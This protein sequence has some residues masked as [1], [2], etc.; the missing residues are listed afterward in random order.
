[1]LKEDLG[2][3]GT[4]V[5]P[6]DQWKEHGDEAFSPEL[7]QIGKAVAEQQ[8]GAECGPFSDIPSH[9]NWGGPQQNHEVVEEKEQSFVRPESDVVEDGE[10]SGRGTE[11]VVE[12]AVQSGRGTEEGVEDGEQSGRGTEEV[13]ED[14]EQSDRGTEEGVQDGEQ[15]LLPVVVETNDVG[16]D[17]EQSPV[18]AETTEVVDRKDDRALAEDAEETLKRV[19]ELSIDHTEDLKKCWTIEPI[20]KLWLGYC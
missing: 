20:A 15:R 4:F 3:N 2:E 10:Q 9:L 13:V 8:Q 12:D 7:D 19:K 11:E 1:M 17:D 6:L 14:G 16:G 18:V 5:A